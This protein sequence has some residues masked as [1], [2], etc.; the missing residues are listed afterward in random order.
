MIGGIIIKG[1]VRGFCFLAD[2]IIYRVK[3]VGLENV[4]KDKGAIICGN[5]VHAL[6][7]PALAA[8]CTRK[9]RFMAKKELFDNPGIRFMSWVYG[10]FPV[11]RDKKDTEAIKK[12]LKILKNNEILG[13]YPEGTRNGLAKGVKPKNGAVNIAMRAGVPVIPFGVQGTFKPF[14]KVVYV[15]GEPIDYSSYKDKIH[16]KEFVGI[17][18]NELMAKIVELRDMD[19][20]KK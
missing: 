19:Y 12:S 1:I 15:F 20:K 6:D 14:T 2:K 11:D 9:I 18:T 8:G 16:D 13:I 5:H 7:A 3:I 10:S 4:P 17:L